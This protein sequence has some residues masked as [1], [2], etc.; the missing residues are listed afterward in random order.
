MPLL[1]LWGHVSSVGSPAAW[2]RIDYGQTIKQMCIKGVQTTSKC[3]NIFSATEIQFDHSGWM[4]LGGSEGHKACLSF[5]L[6]TGENNTVCLLLHPQWIALTVQ[7]LTKCHNSCTRQS[8]STG[9]KMVPTKLGAVFCAFFY[10][11]WKSNTHTQK[12]TQQINV[13]WVAQIKIK[14]QHSQQQQWYS[15][16]LAQTSFVYFMCVWTNHISLNYLNAQ[17]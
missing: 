14:A 8:P 12:K 4:C 2:L 5:S 11:V 16:S 17:R 13:H 3:S 7:H 10:R 9:T 15:V 6:W 1:P